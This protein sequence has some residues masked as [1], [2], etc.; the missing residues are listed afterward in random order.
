MVGGVAAGKSSSVG[1]PG[2]THVSLWGTSLRVSTFV[3][4]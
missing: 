1:R 3:C 2:V 4:V